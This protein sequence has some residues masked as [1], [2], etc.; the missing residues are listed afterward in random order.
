MAHLDIV[1]VEHIVPL[2][3][4]HVGQGQEVADEGTKE[5]AHGVEHHLDL[6]W[7][8]QHFATHVNDDES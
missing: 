3:H 4:V 6:G 1:N 2:P 5:Q 8:K 7:D